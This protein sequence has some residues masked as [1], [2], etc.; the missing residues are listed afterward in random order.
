MY[1]YMHTYNIM[2]WQV[3]VMN[4]GD[5]AV[6]REILAPLSHKIYK[7]HPPILQ[8]PSVVF[9]IFKHLVADATFFFFLVSF[10]DVARS[11]YLTDVEYRKY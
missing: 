10:S 1:K 8:L 3:L 5:C 9:N 6:H 2:G 7:Q 4:Y 11:T